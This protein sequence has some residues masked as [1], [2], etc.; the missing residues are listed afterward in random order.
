M[1]R[2]IEGEDRS[3]TTLLPP[4]PGRLRGRGQ[5][6]AGGRSVRRANSICGSWG[7]RVPPRLPPGDRLSPGGAA[8]VL[9]LR[10]SEPHPVEPPAGAR[11]AAQR[12]ADVADR[13][14]D[15]RLQDHR[16][17]PPRQRQA[18]RNVCRQFVV[19]CRQLDLFT[20]ALVA[21]DGSKFKA[22]NNR[23]H[24]FTPPSSSGGWP[25]SSES[26]ARYLAALDTADRAEPEVAA[27]RK[28]SCK[29]KIAA[30]KEQMRELRRSRRSCRPRTRRR[31][32]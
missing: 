29:D 21:I 16:Q 22:V 17:L 20:Q 13:A 18:I 15:A 3:Q 25:R 30:L 26:I 9:H 11:S 24:N 19:L 32:R 27:R 6:G 31:S 7:S 1:K 28:A 10:L 14:P 4:S 5:P 12:R 23:D 2:F 8:Q